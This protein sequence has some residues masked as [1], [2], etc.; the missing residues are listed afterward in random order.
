MEARAA[1]L[2]DADLVE[3]TL[4]RSVAPAPANDHGQEQDAEWREHHEEHLVLEAA[5][6]QARER[7]PEPVELQVDG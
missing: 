7:Q 2:A 1:V 6:L 5:E 3:R 4:M